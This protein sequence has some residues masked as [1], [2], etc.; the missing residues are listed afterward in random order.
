LHDRQVLQGKGGED[1]QLTALANRSAACFLPAPGLP[2]NRRALG[3]FLFTTI[4]LSSAV[5]A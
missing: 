5:A 4:W 3:I 2:V 1:M